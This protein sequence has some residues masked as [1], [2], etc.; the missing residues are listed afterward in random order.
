MGMTCSV[1]EANLTSNPP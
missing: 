1:N